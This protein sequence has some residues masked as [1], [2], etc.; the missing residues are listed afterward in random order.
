MRGE[1]DPQKRDKYDNPGGRRAG[2]LSSGEV[3]TCTII[4]LDPAQNGATAGIPGLNRFHPRPRSDN[5]M[6]A[7]DDRDRAK[8]QTEKNLFSLAI[9]GYGL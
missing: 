8:M 1:A 6:D 3:D 2:D 9:Q 5:R 7:E 4:S